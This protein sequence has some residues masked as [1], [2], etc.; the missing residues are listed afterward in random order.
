MCDV[1]TERHSLKVHV[2]IQAKKTLS[3]L[4]SLHFSNQLGFFEQN[5]GGEN[6]P[7]LNQA[8]TIIMTPRSKLI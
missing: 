5:T 8:L 1:C 3:Q 6:V 7:R 4:L 2:D